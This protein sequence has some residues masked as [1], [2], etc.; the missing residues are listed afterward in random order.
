M[1]A[2]YAYLDCHTDAQLQEKLVDESQIEVCDASHAF[3]LR[4]SFLFAIIQ[5][6]V[7]YHRNEED[8]HYQCSKQE[9]ES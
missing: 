3:T 6:K 9:N 7:K 8:D 2:R 5:L 4:I 1:C